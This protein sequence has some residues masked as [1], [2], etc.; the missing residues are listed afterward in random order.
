MDS[1]LDLAS[2]YSKLEAWHDSNICLDKAISIDF[3]YPKCWHV[4]GNYC[5]NLTLLSVQILSFQWILIHKYY[6]QT[7]MLI[8]LSNIK[9]KL[10]WIL[11]IV[12][13]SS[14]GGHSVEISFICIYLIF[15][16][17][18]TSKKVG[19]FLKHYNTVLLYP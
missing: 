5:W 11:G 1:W 19:W 9:K 16:V 4:R 14:W 10:K 6:D 15:H 8:V 13:F 7:T 12:P 3:F 17:L 18:W 2:I